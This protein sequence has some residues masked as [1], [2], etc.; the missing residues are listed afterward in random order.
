MLSEKGTVRPI[1]RQVVTFLRT[2]DYRVIRELGEGACG[3]TILLHDEQ[4]DEHFVC[5][6]YRPYSEKLRAELFQ[7]FCREV[8]LLHRLY[9]TNVVRVFNHYLYPKS[10]TGYILMEFV[11]GTGIDEYLQQHPDR[12]DH[13]FVQAIAGFAYLEASGVLHRDIRAQNLMVNDDGL[14]K[15]IDLGFAKHVSTAIDFKKSIT[16]NWHCSAPAE[17]AHS[18]YDFRSEVY[19]VGKLFENLIAAN[20][21]SD[22]KYAS[23]LARMCAFNCDD[24]I[25]SFKAVETAVQSGS[26]NEVSFDAQELGAY[27]HFATAVFRTVAKIHKATTYI[28][29]PD[30]VLAKLSELLET[31]RLE[32]L[33]PNPTKVIDAVIA[34]A[35][36][37][38][39]GTPDLTVECLRRFVDLLRR[40]N[41]HRRRI[42]VSN[43]HAKLDAID[44]YAADDLSR[45][46]I[47]F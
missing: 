28:R 40:S 4:I 7:S 33:I 19:F 9:H 25:E 16:L 38:R 3:K 18:I 11:D 26:F 21:I 17:F 6:K 20:G 41:D 39:K 24:R 1:E 10:H 47:P 29:E 12:I 23:L 30:R 27:R 14:L 15:I 34:G 45:D 32:E 13:C 44:R 42:I 46:D 2:R 43:L 36:H 5:K 31:V 8:K 37:Y 22:F 35:Y